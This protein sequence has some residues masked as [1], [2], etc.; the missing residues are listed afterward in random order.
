VV[1]DFFFGDPYVAN[2]SRTIPDWLKTHGTVRAQLFLDK[3]GE[4][5]LMVYLFVLI[6][7]KFSLN[8]ASI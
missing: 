3:V 1:P 5:P 4:P 6:T 7:M 2:T 8:H